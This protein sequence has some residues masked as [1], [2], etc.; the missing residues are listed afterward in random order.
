[1]MDYYEKWL[2]VQGAAEEVRAC[3]TKV[4]AEHARVKKEMVGIKRRLHDGYRRADEASAMLG[5]ANGQLVSA[6]VL[7]K[8]AVRTLG[9]PDALSIGFDETTAEGATEV[10]ANAVKGENGVANKDE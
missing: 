3:G 8:R 9:I 2:A 1:M 10:A 5:K 6:K 4:Q 7:V